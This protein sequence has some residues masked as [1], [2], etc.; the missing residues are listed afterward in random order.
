MTS[1]GSGHR[2]HHRYLRLQLGRA[3]AVADAE[4]KT[5]DES[6]EAAVEPAEGEVV[7]EAPADEPAADPEPA[8]ETP[9]DEQG[10]AEGDETKTDA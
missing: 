3:D 5:S 10:S 6:G 7:E 4:A 8:E 1:G 2:P 9:A